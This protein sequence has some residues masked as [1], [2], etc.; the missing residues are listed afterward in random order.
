MGNV[1]TF[2]KNDHVSTNF[3]FAAL[4]IPPHIIYILYAFLQS[5]LPKQNK[6][7]I[8]TYHSYDVNSREL[9]MLL[10]TAFIHVPFISLLIQICPTCSLLSLMPTHH[11]HHLGPHFTTRRA[12]TMRSITTPPLLPQRGSLPPSILF[13]W[14][15][16]PSCVFRNCFPQLPPLK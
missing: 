16:N 2:L 3:S 1:Q 9:S 5:Q 11:L 8:F 10:D 12:V 7:H 13:V 15:F 14:K 6:N 4:W